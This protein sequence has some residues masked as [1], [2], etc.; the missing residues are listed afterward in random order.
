M[1]CRL[2]TEKAV[3]AAHYIEEQYKTLLG[4][5]LVEKHREEN[6]SVAREIAITITETEKALAYFQVYVKPNMEEK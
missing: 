4:V 5:L 6:R 1:R 2:S 3:P